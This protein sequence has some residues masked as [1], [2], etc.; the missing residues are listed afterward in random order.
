MNS[1]L[2]GVMLVAGCASLPPRVGTAEQAALPAG[3]SSPLDSVLAPLEA[4]NPGE[5]GFHLVTDGVEAFALRGLGARKAARSIDVQ[6]YIWHDDLSGR[7]LARELL[8]AA[9][10]GVRVRILLDDLDARANNFALAGLDAHPL[11]EVRLFNPFSSRKGGVVKGI[12]FIGNFSRMNHRMHNKNW[13]VD[14]RLAISGGRNIG[15]EYFAASDGVNF[16]D[17]DFAMVGPGV[18]EVSASFDAYWNSTVVWPVAALSPELANDASLATLRARHDG[19]AVQAA[20][21]Q[22]VQSLAGSDVAARIQAGEIPMRWTSRWQVLAD[23]PLKAQG[24]DN[25]IERSAVLRGLLAAMDGSQ[26]SIRLI[27]PYFV[28]GQKGTQLLATLD[29][30]GRR[31][32]V[33]TNSL[34]A[35]DVAAVH[36]GYSRHRKELLRN[37]VELWELKPQGGQAASDS[38]FGSSGASLHT[39]AAIFDEDTVLVGSFNLDPRSVSLNCEQGVFASDPVLAAELGEHYNHMTSP[40]RA[41]RV[42]LDAAGKLRWSD[43]ERTLDEEPEASLKRR[44]TAW[45]MRWLP[46][47]SQL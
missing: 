15:D 9:D 5:T 41:W 34:A 2:L 42:E 27:S 18:R 28:P 40:E 33:L 8:A 36:G 22:W 1:L 37:G 29:R 16:L 21:S 26:T 17:T 35:N 10:R 4:R 46:V 44:T 47:Q 11:I 13:I 43:G 14:N 24:D 45:L 19:L 20:E 7:L 23:D 30:D 6:Y 3:D 38:L 31:V 25:P 39:K 32:S 12:E